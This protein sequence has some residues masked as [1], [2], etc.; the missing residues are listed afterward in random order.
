MGKRRN[1]LNNTT[2]VYSGKKRERHSRVCKESL[3]LGAHRI[4]IARTKKGNS[5]TGG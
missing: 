2:R 4:G 3:R 1:L 5:P